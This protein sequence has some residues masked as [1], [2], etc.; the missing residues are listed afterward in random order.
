MVFRGSAT[1]R[2]VDP[3][4]NARLRLATMIDKEN[5]L[6]VGVV[7]WNDRWKCTARGSSPQKPDVERL[8]AS[9]IDL[10]QRLDLNAQQGYKYVVYMAG[11]CASSRYSA[12]MRQGSVILK[13]D[14]MN[15]VPGQLWFFHRL[16]PWRDHVPVRADLSDLNERLVWCRQNPNKCLDMVRRCRVLSRTLLSRTALLRYAAC[17]LAQL[18]RQKRAPEHDRPCTAAEQLQD[19]PIASPYLPPGPHNGQAP[20][21]ATNGKAWRNRANKPQNKKL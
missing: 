19:T 21:G 1:G 10:L 14:D 20:R 16:E 12:L 15:D 17:T 7:G 18:P 13:V 11:H 2:G 8:R 6:D 5:G 3:A 9:G 4:T